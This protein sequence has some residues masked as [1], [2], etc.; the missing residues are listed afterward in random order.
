LRPRWR[1]TD[2]LD[3]IETRWYN[4]QPP[5]GKDVEDLLFYARELLAENQKLRRAGDFLRDCLTE[6]PETAR[7][8][9][10]LDEWETVTRSAP[11]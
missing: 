3:A 7:N 4:G 2:T 8:E 11:G 6:A 10:A 1:G 5:R 9:S